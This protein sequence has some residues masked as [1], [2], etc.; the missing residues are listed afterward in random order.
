[1][2]RT[3]AV[4]ARPIKT[5]A[6]RV[7]DRF[8][9]DTITVLMFAVKTNPP[10]SLYAVAVPLYRSR[11]CTENT[12]ASIVPERSAGSFLPPDRRTWAILFEII[13]ARLPCIMFRRLVR[14]DRF[15]D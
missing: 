15:W 12:H 13:P 3:G 8:V 4:R 11:M 14:T 7:F 9:Y 2:P 5:I 1:V 10:P 6:A